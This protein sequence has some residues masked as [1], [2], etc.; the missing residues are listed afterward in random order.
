M[1]I[2]EITAQQTLP[3]R[4]EA[5]WPD[6]PLGYV[7]LPNDE[8]GRHY[9]LFVQD[10]LI[11]VISLFK[12]GSSAQFR[13]FATL[14]EFQ[15]NGY[16]TLLLKYVMDLGEKECLDRIWCNARIHKSSYYRKFGLRETED[17]FVKG[18]ISY[19]VMEKIFLKKGESSL[20]G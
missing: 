1:E 16:G 15:G 12:K 10:K 8:A 20:S 9:G 17:H 5:M 11:S 6:K 3:I 14:T 19:V 18:G 2:Q 4:H 13:K 7:K